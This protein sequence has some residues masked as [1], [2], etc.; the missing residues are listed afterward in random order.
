MAGLKHAHLTD[1][2]RNKRTRD[3][4][5]FHYL[6]MRSVSS[7]SFK[8]HENASR[9]FR[10]YLYFATVAGRESI[11]HP[12]ALYGTSN[13]LNSTINQIDTVGIKSDS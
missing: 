11:T 7:N 6:Q 13:E 10:S 1:V 12:R 8:N 2:C 5:F 3:C 4:H 9:T